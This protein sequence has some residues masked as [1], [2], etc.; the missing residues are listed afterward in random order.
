[1]TKLYMLLALLPLVA[2]SVATAGDTKEPERRMWMTE[3]GDRDDDGIGAV[4]AITALPRSGGSNSLVI[5]NI[6]LTR[7]KMK[8]DAEGVMM[9]ET[10]ESFDCPGPLAVSQVGHF[11]FTT[12]SDDDDAPECAFAVAGKAWHTY[13]PW[14]SWDFA[15]TVS[16]N[17][18]S[19]AFRIA[20]P[21]PAT[22]VEPDPKS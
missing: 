14:R 20:D 22:L 2:A 15:G 1:M 8:E 13:R 7:N 5:E 6:T 12:E 17:D 11:S 18:A 16:V 19:I 10:L 21:A 9:S 4:L 3:I